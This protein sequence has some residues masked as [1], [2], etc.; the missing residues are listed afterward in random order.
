MLEIP[1]EDLKS[2]QRELRDSF[3]QD[4]GLRVHRA[5]SWL[6]RAEREKDDQDAAF[7]FLWIAFNAAY[8]D[9]SC[10]VEDRRPSEKEQFR[11]VLEQ[12]VR[13]DSTG[14]LHRAIWQN[15]QGPVRKLISNR[16][17]FRPFWQSLDDRPDILDWE[18][19]FVGA[20]RR[21]TR[22]MEAKD[23]ATVLSIVFD[24]L[25]MLRNQMMHGSTTW[26]SSVNRDQVNDGAQIL[27]T[28][29]PIMVD[30]ML[31]NPQ[32]DWGTPRYPV[33]QAN[34]FPTNPPSRRPN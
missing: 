27:A 1:F 32:E 31:D 7:I 20:A 14:W 8:A 26:N 12:L 15:F 4:M 28:L 22:A 16:F 30:L 9:Q 19:Q 3:P 17:I 6:G 5:I 21:F 2:K 25:Y 33:L 23:T 29:V 18:R 11:D 34:D 13:L 24:R 10:P